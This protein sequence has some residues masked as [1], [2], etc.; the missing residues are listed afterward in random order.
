MTEGKEKKQDTIIT[1]IRMPKELHEILRE[2]SFQSK[3]SINQLMVEVLQLTNLQDLL[4][5]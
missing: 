4:N 3:K 2:I 1:T 5:V